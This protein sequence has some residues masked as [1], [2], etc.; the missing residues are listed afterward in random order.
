MPSVNSNPINETPIMFS[1]IIPIKNEEENILHLFQ[2][3]YREMQKL[4][5]PWELI[6]IDDGSTDG[7]TKVL[8][9]LKSSHQNVRVIT[10]TKNYGQSSAF[11]AGFKAARGQFIISMDGDGQND[12]ADIPSL[13]RSIEDCDLVC[14]WRVARHDP[15]NKK[16]ISKLSNFV[17][18]KTC[19]DG[20]HDNG[21]S[22]KIYRSQCLKAIKMYHGMH[23]F[24]PAL[25]ILENFRVKEIP[26]N[27]RERVKGKSNYH[28]FNRSLS[29]FL[30]MFAVLWMRKRHLH[31]QVRKEG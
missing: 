20:M 18:N 11:D 28:F 12:P 8:K 16:I 4:D 10:F 22:L 31:Y 19:K 14:G 26:V 27:H 1:V 7:S 15:W 13:V 30:D 21:C 3:I 9:N 29:P 5:K 24:L 2:E 23:R 25:F 6:F 17:R